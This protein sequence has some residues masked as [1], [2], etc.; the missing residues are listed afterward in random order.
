MSNYLLVLA[1]ACW[2]IK[3]ALHWKKTQLKRNLD[4][5]LIIK[6]TSGNEED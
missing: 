2:I 3:V 5:S 4:W 1:T 6:K